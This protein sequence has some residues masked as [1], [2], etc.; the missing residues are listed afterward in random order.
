MA[1]LRLWLLDRV[2]KR[3]APPTKKP[4]SANLDEDDDDLDEED[5]DFSVDEDSDLSGV[6]APKAKKQESAAT[7]AQGQQQKSPVKQPP[8]TPKDP[9]VAAVN[10]KRKAE[11]EG[12]SSPAKR[13]RLEDHIPPSFV[14]DYETRDLC[15]VKLTSFADGVTKDDVKKLCKDG[16][17]VREVQQ[18]DKLV[19]AYVRY[20]TKE[21]AVAASRSL[22]GASLKGVAI[23]ASYCGD[24]WDNP[25]TRPQFQTDLLD[26]RHV[27]RE[28][29]D[30][31]KLAALFPTGEVLKV[32]RDGY[33]QVKFPSNEALIKALKD[34]KCWTI[35]NQDLEFAVALVP[36]Q[37]GM[38][39]KAL[40]I[41]TKRVILNEL[42]QGAKNC[43]LVK[44]YGVSKS[45]ISTILK[46]KDKIISADANSTDRKRLRRATYADVEE[47]LL[48]WFVDARARNI[49][50]SGPMMLAKAKDFAFLLDFPDFCPGNGWLHRFKGPPREGHRA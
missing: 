43:E 21:K 4:L 35:N 1:R 44:K 30:K 31:E 38:K 37:N 19:C 9:V 36:R 17:V 6:P 16:T 24:R 11:F 40:D 39:R 14:I 33:A 12:G 15:D 22:Q 28:Y 48:K 46:N 10:G 5:D 27:P 49:P 45:T 50:I 32:H 18:N 2:P 29:L 42:A 34:P 7:K 3:K 20:A 8:Q 41:S 25:A 47:A 26:V 23:K 13:I